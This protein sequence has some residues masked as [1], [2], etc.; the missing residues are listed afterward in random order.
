LLPEN[1]GKRIF[2]R[3]RITAKHHLREIVVFFAKLPLT[4]CGNSAILPWISDGK[5]GSGRGGKVTSLS[6]I[7]ALMQY[8]SLTIKMWQDRQRSNVLNSRQQTTTLV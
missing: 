7:I 3:R 4:V 5:E 2:W 8:G 6:A 1:A